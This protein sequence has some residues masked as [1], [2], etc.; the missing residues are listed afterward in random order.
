MSLFKVRTSKIDVDHCGLDVGV[1]EESLK[2]ER[3]A[4]VLDEVRRECVSQQMWVNSSI[5]H[6]CSCGNPLDDP[7]YVPLV[8]PSSISRRE[9]GITIMPIWTNLSPSSEGSSK[10]SSNIDLPILRSLA[11]ANQDRLGVKINI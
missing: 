8:E 7:R 1:T 11:V 10:S 2:A 3:I 9:V 4:S 6:S 5:S